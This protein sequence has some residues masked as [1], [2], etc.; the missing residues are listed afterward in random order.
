MSTLKIWGRSS[1]VNVQK[2]MWAVGELGVLHHR[3]DAGG[4]F[5]GL[6]AEDFIAMNPN[7]LVPVMDDG[8]FILW[9]SNAI[10]R[11]LAST[12]GRGGLH[13]AEKRDIARA[14][15]W[16]DWAITSLYAD[17]ISTCFLGLIRTPAS[18][19][20][21][22][23]VAAA[24]ERVGNKLA[25]LDKHLDGRA[26][27]G[28][29]ELTMADIPAGA[30]MYRYFTLPIQR[31]KLPNVEAW[32]QRLGERPAYQRHVMLDYSGLKVAGA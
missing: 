31:P 9:E 18:E 27:I 25:L 21:T 19:R 11:Y 22:A 2:V 24:A 3:I 30:Y 32:Y 4:A 5:G 7:R 12:Y 15:Q 23:A 8:G 17:I 13:P 29:A 16:M 26:F 10:I 20:N 1:S 28:G 14:D 6:D